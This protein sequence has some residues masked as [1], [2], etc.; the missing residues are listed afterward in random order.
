MIHQGKPDLS[1]VEYL[2]KLNWSDDKKGK[3][4]AIVTQFMLMKEFKYKFKNKEI[5]LIPND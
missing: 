4:L 3:N 2:K 1:A 5:K